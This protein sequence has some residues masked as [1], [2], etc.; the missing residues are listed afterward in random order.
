MKIK[1]NFLMK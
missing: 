1:T